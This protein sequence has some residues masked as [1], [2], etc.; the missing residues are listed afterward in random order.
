M[1]Y[2]SLFL[3]L[4]RRLGFSDSDSFCATTLAVLEE[5]RFEEDFLVSFALGSVATAA[6]TAA[7]AAAVTFL[8]A[9]AAFS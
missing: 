5:A 3:D 6:I 4:P 1:S 8:A 7:A 9:F 2:E